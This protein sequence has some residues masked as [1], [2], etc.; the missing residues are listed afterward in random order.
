MTGA[1]NKTVLIICIAIVLLMVNP[2]FALDS[3]YIENTEVKVQYEASLKSVASE[4][5]RMY[6]SV[7]Q[8]IEDTF[9]A[10]IFFN[11]TVI[12]IKD[13]KTFTGITRNKSVVAVAISENNLIIIDNSRMKTHPFTLEVTLK[14]ELCHLFLHD[15]IKDGSLPRWFN[16]GVSQWVSGGIAE[17]IIQENKDL[18][19][20][21]TLTG[22][23]ISIRDLADGFPA[24]DKYLHLAYQQ[25][26]SIVNYIVKEFGPSGILQ[27]MDHLKD[28]ASINMAVLNALSVSMEDLEK[29]WHMYLRK[30]YTWFT[31]LSNHLY[32]I[33]FSFAALALTY[34]FVRMLLRKRAYKDEEE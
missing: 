25:S 1:S 19:K 4:V 16:E 31:Y 26:R 12:L 6:S 3:E 17:L 32:E 14:H 10:G 22:R 30:K 28:N 11:P 2:V 24:D 20:Q 5:V 27:I 23:L 18:L 21:A 9:Q 29:D 34:G 7:K 13:R 8:E 33:L 15:Y